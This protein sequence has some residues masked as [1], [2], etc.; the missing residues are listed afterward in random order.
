MLGCEFE[1][2]KCCTSKAVA[3]CRLTRDRSCAPDADPALDQG[4]RRP[5]EARRLR[6]NAVY[7]NSLIARDFDCLATCRMAKRAG[8]ARAR[9][10]A[11]P[12]TVLLTVILCLPGLG[13][14]RWEAVSQEAVQTVLTI[15]QENAEAAKPGLDFKECARG[16]PVM[17][18]VPAGKFLMGSPEN[19]SEDDNE[20]PQHEVTV[21]KPFAVSK[22]EVTYE[23]WEA[24]VAAAACRRVPD[25]F[26]RGEMPMINVSWGDAKQYAGW[27]LR[28]TGKEY[29][30]LTEAEW[31]YAARAGTTARYS[32]GDDPGKGN[33][34]CDGCGSQWDRQHT[35]PVGS[36]KPNAFGLYDMHGNVWEWVED[37]WHDN[38]NGA[39]TDGSAWHQGGDP[40]YRVIRGG[41]WRNDPQLVRAALRRKRISGVRFD[42]LGFRVARTLNP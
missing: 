12:V 23:E 2:L 36:F 41:S 18:V 29:R 17:I 40:S 11:T 20:R 21:A 39:P 22:F 25:N 4:A 3:C 31:E 7:G 19:E 14:V 27:L 15:E 13:F 9:G 5:P 8:L 35:A 38:Y 32:W 28:L 16:C 26:G 1:F 6:G 34:N 42:T 24:C 30:L 10:G 37:S 33:A